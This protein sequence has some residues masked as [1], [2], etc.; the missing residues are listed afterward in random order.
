MAAAGSPPEWLRMKRAGSAPEIHRIDSLAL[1]FQIV[2]KLAF[3]LV[4]MLDH[5]K[6]M[7]AQNE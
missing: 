1:Q 2:E 5:L 6:N 7:P 3:V 4:Q